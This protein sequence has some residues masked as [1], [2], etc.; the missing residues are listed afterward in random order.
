MKRGDD[1]ELEVQK[2]EV[3]VD[4]KFGRWKTFENGHAS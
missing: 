4:R 2:L 1:Q 3:G